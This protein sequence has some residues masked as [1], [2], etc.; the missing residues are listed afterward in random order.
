MSY[1]SQAITNKYLPCSKETAQHVPAGDWKYQQE[2]M[3]CLPAQIL[4]V[5]F[6]SFWW[7]HLPLPLQPSHPYA[8]M[9]QWEMALMHWV[10]NKVII[11]TQIWSSL[12]LYEKRSE[13]NLSLKFFF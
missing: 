2:E 9:T 1:L 10:K 12:S 13:N 6:F 4:R 3:F 5:S 8:N 11:S 7:Q